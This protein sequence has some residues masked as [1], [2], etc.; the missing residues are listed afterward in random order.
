MEF[1]IVKIKGTTAEEISCP[2]CGNW[3]RAQYQLNN[4]RMRTHGPKDAR[5]AASNEIYWHSDFGSDLQKAA[6]EY[7]NS[8]EV[9]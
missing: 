4:I 6:Q 3:V 1:K 5:C 7:V 8:L 9:A 2:E